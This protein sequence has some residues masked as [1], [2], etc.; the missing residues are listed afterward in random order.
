[1]GEKVKHDQLAKEQETLNMSQCLDLKTRQVQSLMS[2]KDALNGN[3]ANLRNMATGD[4]EDA[5]M[6]DRGQRATFQRQRRYA[7]LSGRSVSQSPAWASRSSY[8]FS[9]QSSRGISRR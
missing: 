2:Q 7:T 6:T 9:E 5:M 4:K 3:I 1:M 8:Q